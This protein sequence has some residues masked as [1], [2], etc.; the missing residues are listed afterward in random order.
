MQEQKLQP[1]RENAAKNVFG[2]PII[3]E[4]NYFVYRIFVFVLILSTGFGWGKV[5]KW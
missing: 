5:D 1:I 3:K 4:R 2:T